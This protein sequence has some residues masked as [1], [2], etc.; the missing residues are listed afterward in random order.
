MGQKETGLHQ[1]QCVL[2]LFCAGVVCVRFLPW[3]PWLWLIASILAGQPDCAG[4]ERL[5]TALL[6][7]RGRRICGGAGPGQGWSPGK[8]SP[9]SCNRICKNRCSSRKGVSPD[10]FIGHCVARVSNSKLSG[11]CMETWRSNHLAGSDCPAMMPGSIRLLA[12]A[13]GSRSSSRDPTASRT[14]EAGSVRKPGCFSGDWP[15]RDTF[16]AIPAAAGRPGSN[17]IHCA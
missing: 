8:P 13:G 7:V 12:S 4:V 2:A 6:V 15:P 9:I 11:C 3:L 17:R 14:R 1:A 5:E 16:A 10:W